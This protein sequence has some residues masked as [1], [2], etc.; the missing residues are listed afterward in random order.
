MKKL[1][2]ITSAKEANWY[3]Y[4]KSNL[5]RGIA[6]IPEKRKELEAKLAEVDRIYEKICGLYGE[7]RDVLRDVEV[8][9]C[10]NYYD[11]N[12]GLNDL[13]DDEYDSLEDKFAEFEY[14]SDAYDDVAALV[15]D[16]EYDLREHPTSSRD[17]TR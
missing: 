14:E 5:E 7:M 13:T 15:E 4:Y 2:S 6:E 16:V 11:V 1:K 3:E 17:I 9:E 12:H 10:Y 8:V